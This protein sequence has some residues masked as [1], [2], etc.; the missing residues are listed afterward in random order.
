MEWK[1][2]VFKNIIDSSFEEIDSL[3]NLKA[4]L[5][6]LEMAIDKYLDD[7]ITLFKYTILV[8]EILDKLAKLK[9]ELIINCHDV[10]I[11]KTIVHYYITMHVVK[12]QGV[13]W[14]RLINSAQLPYVP[15]GRIAD[16][17][18]VRSDLPQ[19]KDQDI[20]TVTSIDDISTLITPKLPKVKLRINDVIYVNDNVYKLHS[21]KEVVSKYEID[22]PE[23]YANMDAASRIK[24]PYDMVDKL[25]AIYGLDFINFI[26]IDIKKCLNAYMV[27]REN[28]GTPLETLINTTYVLKPNMRAVKQNRKLLLTLKDISIVK[29]TA[30]AE[31]RKKMAKR[32]EF[33]F[34]CA[35]GKELDIQ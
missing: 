2:I 26:K 3:S 1:Q 12:E 29:R 11:D 7:R 28:P 5:A 21:P 16:L 18:N 25:F 14:S 33:L 10:V 32:V 22:L 27:I 35:D 8:K 4:V 20:V 34:A 9:L 13:I 17:Y 24:Y 19:M 23:V 31:Y 30:L 15:I 6:D